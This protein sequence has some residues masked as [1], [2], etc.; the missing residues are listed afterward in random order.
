VRAHGV[1]MVSSGFNENLGLLEGVEDL[2]VQ[3]FVTHPRI[4]TLDIAVGQN[5]R[6]HPMPTLGGGAFG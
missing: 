3:E 2:P 5:S 6:L 4:D 1:V